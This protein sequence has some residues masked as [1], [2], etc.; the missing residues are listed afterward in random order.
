ML[1][2]PW[3]IRPE[4]GSCALSL[5]EGRGQHAPGVC[6]KARSTCTLS[7]SKGARSRCAGGSGAWRRQSRTVCRAGLRAARPQSKCSSTGWFGLPPIQSSFT[8]HS[9]AG[10]RM[11]A[12]RLRLERHQFAL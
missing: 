10:W 7:L 12:G 8:Q 1:P 6:R 2:Q 11:L 4:R 5:V 3:S 9:R